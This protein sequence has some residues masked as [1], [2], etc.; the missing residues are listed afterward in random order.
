M[1]NVGW[2]ESG[3]PLGLQILQCSHTLS[4]TPQ[5]TNRDD[6]ASPEMGLLMVLFGER[7]EQSLPKLHPEHFSYFSFRS[8]DLI[9]EGRWWWWR[10]TEKCSF[11]ALVETHC[12]LGKGTF[13]K[14]LPMGRSRICSRFNTTVGRGAGGLWRIHPGWT[15]RYCISLR[16]S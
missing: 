3:K 10:A 12:N 6:G 14:V 8:K 16:L 4:L 9:F 11:R 13:K 1:W 5:D 15:H 2:H 7:E